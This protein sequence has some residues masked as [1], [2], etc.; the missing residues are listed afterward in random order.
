M[1]QT[2]IH[3]EFPVN[4]IWDSVLCK[5]CLSNCINA[6]HYQVLN[7]KSGAEEKKI[8]CW[9]KKSGARESKNESD[10]PS[11][12]LK[13]LDWKLPLGWPE[14]LAAQC[15]LSPAKE[16][17]R[18]KTLE[19]HLNIKVLLHMYINSKTWINGFWSNER[20]KRRGTAPRRALDGLHVRGYDN[21]ILSNRDTHTT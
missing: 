1:T 6:S 10:S 5:L 15:L 20:G 8:R 14:S 17:A 9:R 18:H 11:P 3:I 13:I 4:I 12:C 21:H 7:K 19:H 2:P 16:Y